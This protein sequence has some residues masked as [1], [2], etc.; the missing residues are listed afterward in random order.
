MT[1][2]EAIVKVMQDN[3][4]LANWAIIYNEI[5]KYYPNIKNQI[6][7]KSGVR[8]VLY[9]EIKDYKNF[10]KIDDG[11]FALIQ[12]DENLLLLD[13]FIEDTETSTIVKIRKGQSKFRNKLLKGLKLQ[14]PVTQIN[15]KRLIIASHIKPWALSNNAERLD[16]NNGFL[17]SAI[18]DKL[19]DEGLI[20]FSFEKE[21]LISN[22]LSASN[23]K[24][25]G[26]NNRQII[27]KLPIKGRENYLKY[28]QNKVFLQ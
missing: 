14:C 27:E 3:N 21:I 7:W 11:L 24:K 15:D 2:V 17:L 28:H 23:A 1:K 10:K 22:S 9:R 6:E 26:I 18:I 5:E 12:Y 4:G 13:E 19:F 16:I 8:G 25:I 20:T